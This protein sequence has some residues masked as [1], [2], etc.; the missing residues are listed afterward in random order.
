M[1]RLRRTSVRLTAAILVG[2]ATGAAGQGP[3]QKPAAAPAPKGAAAAG[4]PGKPAAPASNGKDAKD[5][6]EDGSPPPPEAPPYEA[7]LLRLGEILGTL[8]YLRELCGDNDAV[9]WRRRM[10]ALIDAEGNTKERKEQLAGAF[11]RGFRGYQFSYHACT[12]AAQTIIE[13]LLDEGDRI[14]RDVTSR[15]AG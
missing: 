9:E 7:K 1:S 10:S 8:S 12:T 15:Y 4:K 3:R 14:T 6:R 2:L 5:A 11:N 13:R